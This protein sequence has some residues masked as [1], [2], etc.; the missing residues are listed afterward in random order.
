MD[1]SDKFQSRIND[2][3]QEIRQKCIAKLKGG[4]YSTVIINARFSV[5]E[6]LEI[7][8]TMADN[9]IKDVTGYLHQANFLFQQKNKKS[10]IVK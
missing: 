9:G 3:P 1:F 7:Y 4:V 8:E 10:N 5:N 6:V 2:L